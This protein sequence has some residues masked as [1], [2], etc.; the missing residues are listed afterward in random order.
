M[1]RSPM[2]IDSSLLEVRNLHTH[3]FTKSGVVKAVDGVDFSVKPG[4]TLG[5]VGESGSGKSITA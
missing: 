3:F 1:R 2:Q 5:I 4:E